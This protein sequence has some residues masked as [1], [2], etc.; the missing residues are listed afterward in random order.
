MDGL[1]Y[2]G[3]PPKKGMVDIL[4]FSPLHNYRVL[5]TEADKVRDAMYGW[6]C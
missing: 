1:R 6:K 5:E 2:Q 4:G 3:P